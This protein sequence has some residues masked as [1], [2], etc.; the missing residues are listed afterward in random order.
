MLW[1]EVVEKEKIEADQL[2][3]GFGIIS[4]ITAIEAYLTT[5][6]FIPGVI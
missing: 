6:Y 4:F 3:V 2:N 5:C 1:L